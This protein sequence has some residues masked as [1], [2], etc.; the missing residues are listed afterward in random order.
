MHAAGR[1]V[2]ALTS[3]L[4]R[5]CPQRMLSLEGELEARPGRLAELFLGRGV[6][7]V[8]LEAAQGRGGRVVAHVASETVRSSCHIGWKCQRLLTVSKLGR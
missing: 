5:C 6:Q 8:I 7:V 3:A 2:G 4:H 1:D